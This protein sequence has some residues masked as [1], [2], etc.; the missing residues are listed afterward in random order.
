M[1]K[2]KRNIY[3]V[4]P[5][6]ERHTLIGWKVTGPGGYTASFK[7]FDDVCKQDA[8]R[9]ARSLATENQPSQVLVSRK[10]RATGKYRIKVEWSYGIDSKA[11]G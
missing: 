4:L 9:L 8:I 7:W 5:I 6:V 10:S 2:P 1:A 11:K 3:R